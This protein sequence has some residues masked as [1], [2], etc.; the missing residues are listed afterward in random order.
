[1]QQSSQGL[2]RI[3]EKYIPDIIGLFINPEKESIDCK[4]IIK[5]VKAHKLLELFYYQLISSHKIYYFEENQIYKMKKT[6]FSYMFNTRKNISKAENLYKIFNENNLKVIALKGLVIRSY[7]KNPDF[8]NMGDWDF[9]VRNDEM[10]TVE[11]IL[12]M[13]GYKYDHETLAHKVYIRDDNVKVEL[14]SSLI[15]VDYYKKRSPY[16][17]N[18][19]N[20]I[21]KIKVSD[22]VMYSLGYNDQ[23]MHLITHMLTHVSSSSIGIRQVLDVALYINNEKD[24]IDFKKFYL[25]IKR[26]D[27]Y[28]FTIAILKICDELFSLDVEEYVRKEFNKCNKE[29]KLMLV[30]AIIEGGLGAGNSLKNTLGNQFGY[31]KDNYKER[32]TINLVKRYMEFIFPKYEVMKEKYA[33]CKRFKI[34]LPIAWI[35]RIITGGITKEISI[36]RKARLISTSFKVSKKKNKLLKLLDI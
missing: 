20:N 35:H 34:L 8:R 36:T 13:E 26:Y 23:L 30:E 22:V 11:E 31:D 5:K 14:H 28:D 12:K 9:L 25:D 24:N 33:Y 3:E 29:L 7:Y 17:E 16:E 21:R 18:V 2:N 32:S 6:T 4:L 10:K 1:M 27:I 15:D 19:F